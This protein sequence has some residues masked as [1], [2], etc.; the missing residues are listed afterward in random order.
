M[1]KKR[2]APE[3]LHRAYGARAHT[4]ADTILS[5]MPPPPPSPAECRCKGRRCLGCSGAAASSFLLRDGDD[6]DYIRLLTESYAVLSDNAPLLP[7]F[8][9]AQR[10]QQRNIVRYTIEMMKRNSSGTVNVLC[11]RYDEWTH[12]SPITD[13][14]CS[15]TW[16]CLLSRIGDDL[17]VHLLKY[18]SIFLPLA[19]KNHLQVT[20]PPINESFCFSRTSKYKR[21]AAHSG[22]Q[23]RKVETEK[24]SKSDA[25]IPVSQPRSSFSID[26]S[27]G[28]VMGD[29]SSKPRK[30]VRLFSWQRRRKRM[31]MNF[32][33]ENVMNDFSTTND[34]K[35]NSNL[36][37]Y[38]GK[39]MT[40]IINDATTQ[41]N[42]PRGKKL[43]SDVGGSLL[44]NVEAAVNDILPLEHSGGA[45]LEQVT[46]PTLGRSIDSGLTG[47]GLK[48]DEL[49]EVANNDNFIVEP[50]FLSFGGNSDHKCE[51]SSN[52]KSCADSQIDLVQKA[53]SL[54]FEKREITLID[55][56]KVTSHCF[57]C[58][59]LQAPQKH[60]IKRQSIFYN[61]GGSKLIFPRNHILN[62]LKP[63]DAGAKSLFRHI[64]SLPGGHETADSLCCIERNDSYIMRS[65]CLYQSVLS[66]LK[67][68]IRKVRR[69]Q[70]LK[71]LRKH[72]SILT[73]GKF[74]V[75]ANG[76]ASKEDLTQTKTPLSLFRVL[77]LKKVYAGL[78][79]STNP[80]LGNSYD[81]ANHR[82]RNVP[83][84]KPDM[85]VNQYGLSGSYCMHRQVV[86]FVWAV[87][88]SV[89]PVDLLGDPYNWRALRRNISK[90]VKLRRFE[91]FCLKQCM[92]GIKMSRS[93]LLLKVA[94]S[95]Y[96][97]C[98]HHKK[99]EMGEGTN[100]LENYNKS[101]H[102]SGRQDIFY[103]RKPVW[104]TLMNKAIGC[105]EER[106]YHFL[107]DKS[108]ESILRKRSYGFSKVRFLVKENGVRPLSNLK[109]PSKVWFSFLERTSKSCPDGMNVKTGRHPVSESFSRKWKLVSFKSVNSVLRELYAVLKRIK[110]EHPEKLGSSVFDYNDIYKKLC[111]FLICLRKGSMTM[112]RMF[113]V[114]GDVSKAFDSVKQDK[115]LSVMKDVLCS[116][117]YNLKRYAQIVC[118]KGSLRVHYDPVSMDQ[119]GE[120][121]AVKSANCVP[122]HST[123]CVLV[124]QVRMKQ[125]RRETLYR[126]LEEH[127]KHN[128]LQL[129]WKFYLQEVGIPQGS[130]LSTLLCS[131]YYGHLERNVIFPFLEKASEPQTFGCDHHLEL[132]VNDLEPPKGEI[133]CLGKPPSVSF[134]K[135]NRLYFT[136]KHGAQNEDATDSNDVILMDENVS[137][138]KCLLMRLTD[139]F[140]FVSTSK[141]QAM[142]FFSRLQRGFSDYN[143]SMNTDKFRMNFD[144]DFQSQLPKK[145]VYTGEDGLS[146]LAWGGLLVNC[147]TLEIQ[148]DYTRYWGIHMSS[149]LTVWAQDK[150]GFHF[151]R[152]LCDYMR[153]K[154]HPIFYDSNINSPAI[155]R[156]N[157]YQ[158]SLICAMKFHCYVCAV[159]NT[160]GGD[161]RYFLEMIQTSLRYMYKVLKKQMH[162]IELTSDLH[163][164]LNLK[165]EELVWLGLSAYVRVLRKK[166]SRYSKLL[167]LLRSNLRTYGRMESTSVDLKYAVDDSHSSLI[168][169]IKY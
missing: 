103:Y 96:C 75:N 127:V 65:N 137:S 132:N 142:R 11:S 94:K 55:S 108:F 34:G 38:V 133:P 49:K 26:K 45:H 97:I 66:L 129:G 43:L 140:L 134:E 161:P 128:I 107:D 48:V 90:F 39:P 54:K 74:S 4:L 36:G 159:P 61:S 168:W 120:T 15:S 139:D 84:K 52:K 44:R 47:V 50:S 73:S 72:C 7:A 81:R 14:L 101:E 56:K 32:P 86:S 151:K 16:S 53:L 102:E 17:M 153:P 33:D 143:C 114:I 164:I 64:F 118:T 20:G 27:A 163:P 167:S 113:I 158:A 2:K 123:N 8:D 152:K 148:A 21:L 25:A 79:S 3:V 12:F 131:F 93:P 29:I 157:A 165:K 68:L 119:S 24:K 154:C 77:T 135:T 166:Q 147:D 109:A 87:C 30:R 78:R 99:D 58:L 145:Q 41:T 62:R 46:F 111:P 126:H 162:G 130:V 141:K 67:T 18:S 63:N 112:P 156:L 1:S 160:G 88:R 35:E 80:S 19:S 28:P 31:R 76:F 98:R 60:Q 40:L 83:M 91:N 70:H 89:I 92:H 71:L 155:V 138:P 57:H 6:S 124:D 125:I 85:Y 150:P 110:N 95:S 105:L 106:N 13:A 146:F 10:R 122:F 37:Q 116:S 42:T 115:L 22:Q 100:M 144:A 82:Q 117:N 51:R 149:T 23:K 9:P 169:K 59:I 136:R 69:C 5:L 104:N 121:D